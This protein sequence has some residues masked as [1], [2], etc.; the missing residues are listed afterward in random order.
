MYS[1]HSQAELTVGHSH[2]TTTYVLTRSTAL[3]SYN[4]VECGP[5]SSVYVQ[6]LLS[7]HQ[8]KFVI[9]LDYLTNFLTREKKLRTVFRDARSSVFALVNEAEIV[10]AGAGEVK[11][12]RCLDVRGRDAALWT[13]VIS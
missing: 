8:N 5:C 2:E 7:L 3:Q 1:I 6:F 4:T 10:I 9:E 11:L 12:V 13:P